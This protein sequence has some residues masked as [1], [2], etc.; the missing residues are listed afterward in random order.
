MDEPIKL[1]ELR[2]ADLY[3]LIGN[4]QV[5][6]NRLTEALNQLAQSKEHGETATV[7]SI[8]AGLSDGRIAE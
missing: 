8:A 1:P 3:T 4:Q 2:L 6:I 7:G 5:H